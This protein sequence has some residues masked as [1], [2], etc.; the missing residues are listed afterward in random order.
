MTYEE[1]RKRK[2]SSRVTTL[3]STSS[4]PKKSKSRKANSTEKVKIQVGIK[5]FSELDSTLKVLKGRAL[6]IA[7][8]PCINANG[9]L[10]EALTKHSKHFRSF[11]G[12]INKYV[13]LYPDNTVVNL[14]PGSS[15]F[16]S[17]KDYKEDLGKPYS[18]MALHL[19]KLECVQKSEAESK[20]DDDLDGP[21]EYN[22]FT[23]HFGQVDS[24][25]EI[26]TANFP[27]NTQSIIPFLCNSDDSADTVQNQSLEHKEVE[28]HAPRAIW[29]FL[30]EKL[31]HMLMFVQSSLTLL[32]P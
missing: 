8:D 1:F 22:N 29:I 31:K 15:Q 11:N 24:E 9:L 13:L 21:E 14:L 6:P 23:S 18:K 32:V 5:E 20:S 4:K 26:L 30:Y 2:E 25:C 16:F 7:V 19:C 10:Q 17:L 28:R 3:P 12:N 27:N